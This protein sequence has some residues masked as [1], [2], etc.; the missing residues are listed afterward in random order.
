MTGN[1]ELK[2]SDFRAIHKADILL[3]GITVIAGINGSGKST[4]SKLLYHTF[5]NANHMDEISRDR[6][7][8]SITPLIEIYQQI[9]GTFP[10]LDGMREFSRNAYSNPAKAKE[11]LGMAFAALQ[12]GNAPEESQR[13]QQI[14]R[15]NLRLREDEVVDA[16]V[17]Q[18]V[19]DER[20]VA[21]D[22]NRKKRPFK[23]LDE[24]VAAEF[25]QTSLAD[26]ITLIEYGLPVFGKDVKSVPILHYIKNT[27]YIYSP[28][29]VDLIHTGSFPVNDSNFHLADCLTGDEVKDFDQELYAHI[30]RDI[31][32]GEAFYAEDAS[33]LY[34]SRDDGQS[35]PLQECAT[36]IKSFAMLQLLLRNGFINDRS[37]IILDEPEAHLH[38]QWIVEYAK[39][40]VDM[41]KRIGA[42][43]FI[44]THNTDMVSA[45]R[46]I[47]EKEETLDNL[48]YYQ[49]EPTSDDGFRFDYR[50][51]GT[52][53]EPIF[54]TFN[55]SFDLIEKYG[56]DIQEI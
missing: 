3:N 24:V 18:R 1:V 12:G 14:I 9:R 26:Q 11:Q 39:V 49:A 33:Q 31:M 56:R 38:P 6:F 28:L 43:F 54:E 46:Y 42:K 23:L 5:E 47:S 15:Y 44:A 48:T 10:M 2:V 50:A 17:A 51:L 32:R 45:L 36:G 19:L 8:K 20:H 55:K 22:E 13:L 34:F 52:D 35:F 25:D 53:I 7:I 37:L 30:S 21:Y 27:N 29:S 16:S 4:L 40:I 41:N